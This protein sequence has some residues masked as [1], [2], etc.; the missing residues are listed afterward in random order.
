MLQTWWIYMELPVAKLL[1]QVTV[2]ASS[3][4][5]WDASPFD[6]WKLPSHMN[7]AGPTTRGA[8]SLAHQDVLCFTKGGSLSA[9]GAFLHMAKELLGAPWGPFGSGLPPHPALLRWAPGISHA[10]CTA[11]GSGKNQ[12]PPRIEQWTL[13]WWFFPKLGFPLLKLPS[14]F[15][16]SCQLFMLLPET[17]SARAF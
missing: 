10:C 11:G 2:S 5:S 15:S 16:G 13:D 12:M 3:S 6:N 7:I 1:E 8:G 9:E 4:M 14:W 17:G